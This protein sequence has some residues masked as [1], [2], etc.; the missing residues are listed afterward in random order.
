MRSCLISRYVL[1]VDVVVSELDV[2][3]SV[4][5][6]IHQSDEHVAAYLDLADGWN[7]SV[8]FNGFPV[9]RPCW[10]SVHQ[11]RGDADLED[12]AILVLSRLLLKIFTHVK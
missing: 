7:H 2:A 11:T 9:C 4:S 5:R 10:R 6:R 12:R 1:T 8:F 3:A